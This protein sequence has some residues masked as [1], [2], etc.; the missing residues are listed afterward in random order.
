MNRQIVNVFAC[1]TF[2]EN[3][4]P[5]ANSLFGRAPGEGM[6]VACTNPAAL[7]G[8]GGE[9]HAYLAAARSANTSSAQPKPWV[10]PE[11][12]IKTP[13]VSVPGLLSAECVSNEK[14]SY[15]ALKVHGDPTD[16][17]ADEIVGDVVVNGQPQANWGLHLIDVQAAMG[18][19]VNIVGQQ[20]KAYQARQK[21]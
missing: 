10:T 20:A 15:L 3:L 5:P 18:N 19:L 7:G 6:A 13:F 16:P 2:R 4:P 1:V 11:Q 8:G 9:L 12:P 14:G 21:K 17:R